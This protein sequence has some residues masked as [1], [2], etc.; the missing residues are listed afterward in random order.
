MCSNQ[1]R[2]HESTEE[3]KTIVQCPQLTHA[4]IV[5]LAHKQDLQP[6]SEQD[7]KKLLQCDAIQDHKWVIFNSS[8][9]GPIEQHFGIEK[10]LEWIC[11]LTQVDPIVQQRKALIKVNMAGDPS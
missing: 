3:F 2:L 11:Q 6:V 1:A 4:P 10:M 7:I 8:C 5:I 9:F